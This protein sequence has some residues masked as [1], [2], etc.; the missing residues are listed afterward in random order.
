MLAEKELALKDENL[1][2]KK[3]GKFYVLEHNVT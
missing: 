1:Q 2:G 3:K